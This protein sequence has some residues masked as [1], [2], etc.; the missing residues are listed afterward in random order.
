M[1]E[2]LNYS[3]ISWFQFILISGVAIVL[4]LIVDRFHIFK[5][6]TWKTSVGYHM[7]FCLVLSL[8]IISFLAVRPLFNFVVL[9]VIF[10]F[11]YKNVFAYIRS[12]FNLYFSNIHMGDRIRVGDTEG[13]LSNINLGGMHISANNQKT[14]VPFDNW[15][16]NNI[17]LLSEA[18]RVPV[19]L[20]VSDNDNRQKQKT[21]LALEKR[22]FEFPYL[23]NEKIDI[24]SVNNEL[25]T[26]VILSSQK[27]KDSLVSNIENAGFVTNKIKES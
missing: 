13:K 17:V 21:I 19:S 27:Y 5:R 9:L 8:V 16:G 26:K 10:G 22:L 11:I 24:Q 1:N 14:F 6:H 23:N 18:G 4:L 7:F 25:E 12:V 20:R 2:I 3:L 15:R